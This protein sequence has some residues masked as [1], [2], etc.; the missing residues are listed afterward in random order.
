ME[1]SD[2]YEEEELQ[3]GFQAGR[4]EIGL[5]VQAFPGRRLFRDGQ[6]NP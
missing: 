2:E 1:Q 6:S 5:M 3:R 4:D